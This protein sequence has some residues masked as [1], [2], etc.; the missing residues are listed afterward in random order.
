MKKIFTSI[1]SALVLGMMFSSLAFAQGS[2][3]LTSDCTTC[4]GDASSDMDVH[5]DITNNSSTTKNV[6]VFKI[7]NLAS[8]HTSLFCYAQNCYAPSTDTTPVAVGISGSSTLL[9]SHTDGFKGTLSPN[10]NAAT[11]TVTYVAFDVDNPT[12]TASIT[13]TFKPTIGKD[14]YLSSNNTLSAAYPNPVVSGITKVKFSLDVAPQRA[15]LKV[16]DLLGKTVK[17]YKF[18]VQEGTAKINT[19]EMKAGIYFYSLEIDGKG[20]ATK[21][22]IV[23]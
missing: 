1:L 13:I 5:I 9:S 6:K 10:G 19:D 17:S 11:S 12:D 7:D 15:K 8:G 2:F 20:V 4:T 21:K 22:L 14:D 3:S 16:Y 23:K 18:N